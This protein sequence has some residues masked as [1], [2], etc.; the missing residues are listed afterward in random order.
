MTVYRKIG[1]YTDRNLLPIKEIFHKQ[2]IQLRYTTMKEV[3]FKGKRGL[4]WMSVIVTSWRL[5]SRFWT[6]KDLIVWLYLSPTSGHFPV[7]NLRSSRNETPPSENPRSNSFYPQSEGMNP[8]ESLNW[9]PR[10]SDVFIGGSKSRKSLT[11]YSTL[12]FIVIS[13][14]NKTQEWQRSKV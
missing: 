13:D 10:K 8:S 7:T 1:G 6:S 12:V 11:V 2:S 5:R 14:P 9:E 3:S 4:R